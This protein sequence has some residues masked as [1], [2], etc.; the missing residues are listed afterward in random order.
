MLYNVTIMDDS[1]RRLIYMDKKTFYIT[2]PI[3]YT[4][5]NLHI[6]HAYTTTICDAIAKYKKMRG[7]DVYYLTGT[8]EHGEKVQ[9]KA[10]EANKTP[11]EFVD[12]LVEGIKELWKTLKI[13]NDYFIRTTDKN[14]EET[15]QKILDTIYTA[16]NKEEKLL[17]LAN[18]PGV[19]VP[20][21]YKPIYTEENE[22]VYDT[23]NT[24]QVLTSTESGVRWSSISASLVNFSDATVTS[25]ATVSAHDKSKGLYKVSIPYSGST[26]AGSAVTVAVSTQDTVTHKD[27]I[28]LQHEDNLDNVY[29]ME[30][31]EDNRILA[32]AYLFAQTYTSY[33]MLKSG[34]ITLPTHRENRTYYTSGGG[35]SVSGNAIG[36][37]QVSVKT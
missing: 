8:D 29:I 35:G 16:S 19:Y 5:G 17:N 31:T 1:L 30:D 34:K 14:H 25:N 10:E 28:L 4:S 9:K 24:G 12:E 18:L 6:G 15:V 7:Y 23:G 37:V 13:E 32:W 26:S 3:Y 36:Y 21:N 27:L 11:K 33:I 20:K 2:T 22:F